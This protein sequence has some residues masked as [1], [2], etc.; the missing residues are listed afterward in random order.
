MT[1]RTAYT[2]SIFGIIAAAILAA[3]TPADKQADNGQTTP[4]PAASAAEQKKIAITAIADHPAL[5]TIRAGVLDGLKAEGFEEG[6]NLTVDF[7]SAQG[8]TANAAQIAK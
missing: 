1:P 5:D 3:C 4:A 8:S 6:K 2:S 7:Q